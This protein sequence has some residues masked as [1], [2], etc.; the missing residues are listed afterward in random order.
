[1]AGSV[2]IMAWLLDIPKTSFASYVEDS[3]SQTSLYLIFPLC[4]RSLYCYT[5]IVTPSVKSCRVASMCKGKETFSKCYQMEFFL[6]CCCSCRI[7]QE[8]QLLSLLVMVLV[9]APFTATMFCLQVCVQE[10]SLGLPTG[11]ILKTVPNLFCTSCTP[12]T[13]PGTIIPA[14]LRR[15]INMRRLLFCVSAAAAA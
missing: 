5:P 15:V 2:L 7:K 8:Q 12:H 1:M 13:L 4:L 3:S 14:F 10:F 6:Y 9:S 11:F